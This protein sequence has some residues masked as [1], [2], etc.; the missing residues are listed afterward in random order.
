M[1]PLKGNIK[2]D[3]A[4]ALYRTVRK[5]R[6]ERVVEIGLAYGISALAILSALAENEQEGVLISIDPYQS[7]NYHNIGRL[8]IQQAGLAQYHQVIEQ[9]DFVALPVL[10]NSE[11][12][13]EFA[14]IDGWHTFDYVLLDFFY[15]DK[16][17]EPGSVI[18][19]NDC[20]YRAIHKVIKF[21]KTHRK[22]DEL[23]V[24]LN[25]NYK[26]RN[27]AVSFLRAILR[28]G[29][30]DRYFIKKEAWE[31]TWDYFKPF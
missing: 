23:Y 25:K 10:L 11:Q 6:P 19:F 5:Y 28:F 14:Y 18:G 30:Q 12:K 8:N 29:K 13:I 4:N 22:Y 1:Y 20:G 26:D 21:M 17:L 15:I 27:I 2:I 3:Y 7:E 16:L 9:P 24:G 31:P